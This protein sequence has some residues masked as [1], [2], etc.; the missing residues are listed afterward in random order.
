[1]RYAPQFPSSLLRGLGL[2]VPGSKKNRFPP[3]ISPAQ[4]RRCGLATG[5]R[6]QSSARTVLLARADRA[7]YVAYSSWVVG[8]GLPVSSE[9]NAS[10]GGF[11]P[12]LEEAD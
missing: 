7:G 10:D 12:H 11:V 5:P 3:R 6:S 2:T 8:T 1:M 4:R 9:G